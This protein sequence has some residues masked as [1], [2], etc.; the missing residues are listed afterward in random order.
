MLV[1]QTWASIGPDDTVRDRL[2]G[3]VGTVIL[4]QLKQPDEASALAGTRWV[5][6]RTEQTRVL[7]HTGIG[8]QRAGNRYVVHPDDVRALGNGESFVIHGGQAMRVGVR[9]PSP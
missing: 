7:G 5:M 4:H 6:E 1:G 3:T 9:R 2:A 8:S